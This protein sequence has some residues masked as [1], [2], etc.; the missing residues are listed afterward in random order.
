M[1]M[2]LDRG[3]GKGPETKEN[4]QDQWRGEANTFK[5]DKKKFQRA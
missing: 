3:P 5:W 4:L 2:Y 1:R